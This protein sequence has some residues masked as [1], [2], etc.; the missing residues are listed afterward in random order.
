LVPFNSSAKILVSSATAW[1]IA[2][3]YRI[4][5]LPEAKP[6]VEAYSQVLQHKVSASRSLKFN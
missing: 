3:K 6:L 1:E 2:T 5:K 4:G